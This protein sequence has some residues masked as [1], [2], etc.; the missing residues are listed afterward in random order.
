MVMRFIPL[1]MLLA[2]GTAQQ[3]N[4][5]TVTDTHSC[6]WGALPTTVQELDTLCC[7]TASANPGSRCAGGV[8]CDIPC[9]EQILP[10]INTCHPVIDKLFD[11]DDGVTDGVA[12]QFDSVYSACLAIPPTVALEALAD[13]HCPDAQLNGVAET[14]VGAPP[15]EDNRLGCEHLLASGYMTCAAD[16]GPLGTMP[17]ACDLTCGYCIAPPP[18]SFLWRACPS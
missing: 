13:M 9:A 5:P 15:C 1:M 2:T 6:D 8:S 11:E 4:I 10:F 17:G 18:Q 12:G 3:L 16:F 14:Q 7:F